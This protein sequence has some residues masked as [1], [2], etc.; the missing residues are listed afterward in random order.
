MEDN[1]KALFDKINDN[2]KKSLTIKVIIIGFLFLIFMIPMA[3]IMEMIREREARHSSTINEINNVWGNK[4]I[5]EGPILTIP[6][7]VFIKGGGYKDKLTEA[8]FYAH[9]LPEQLNIKGDISP[10]IRYRS[11]Y[12]SV[13]YNSQLNIDGYFEGLDFSELNIPE[14][15]I[16]WDKAF[17][18]IGVS[19]MRGIKEHIDINWNK[20]AV[21]LKPGIIASRIFG[22][23]LS[24]LI[25]VNKSVQK[26]AFSLNI[27]LNGS[28]SVLFKPIGKETNLNLSSKWQDP[29]FC[30]AFLPKTKSINKEGFTASWKIIDLNRNF[31]QKWINNEHNTDGSEFGVKLIIL[32]NEYQ[33]ITRA[34]K[35][36]M[37][38]ISLTFLVFFFIEI[39]Y[40]NRIHPIQYILVAVGLCIFYILLLSISEHTNFNFAYLVSSIAVISLITYYSKYIF[41]KNTHML[42]MGALLSV[43]YAFFYIIIQLQDY[44]LLMGSISL[45][46]I[47]AYI[48][49]ISRKIDW[50]AGK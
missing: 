17:V 10:E 22:S 5:V 16:L 26:H 21:A 6:Y 46:L 8:V 11:I 7:K 50:Y 3:Y 19:D 29:S 15:N 36:G 20:T 47:L 14:K 18:S 30:G 31:P 35:Y 13:V 49:F 25:P 48:M 34:S 32:V 42:I 39:L 33:K 9:F 2:I 40:K 28:D 24:T 43:S 1:K 45:F 37:I 38:I 44:A 27:D 23:G 4:Q 41:K 12:K